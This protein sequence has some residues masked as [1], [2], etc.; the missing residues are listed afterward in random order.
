MENIVA[1]VQARMKS[2]RLPGKVLRE[3]DGDPILQWVVERLRRAKTVHHV[4]VATTTDASDDAVVDFCRRHQIDFERG[5]MYDV[6]DRY[7]HAARNAAADIVVRV[8]G[9]CPFIDPELVD[10]TVYA[11]LGE[12]A[13]PGPFDFAA[14]RLPPPFHRTYPIGLDTEVCSFAA[15]SRAWQE[16]DRP[17]H[18]EHVMP[19]FYEGVENP[20]RLNRKDKPGYLEVYQSPRGFRVIYLHYD[21]DLGSLRWT[22][23]TP[24]D[25]ALL[26]Q[27]VQRLKKQPIDRWAFRWQEVLDL[28]RREPSLQW[29]NAGVPHK[30]FRESEWNF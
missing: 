14:N 7:Y 23:D 13:A 16:A 24:E 20:I 27:I 11:F 21:Q 22:V 10:E 5:H 29:L 2:S 6:L 19:Y 18:R 8:T 28:V 1:I 12:D 4:R 3:L 17:F 9:D 15:L 30:D 26:E 25:L